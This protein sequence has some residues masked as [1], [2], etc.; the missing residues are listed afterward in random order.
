MGHNMIIS[1]VG[2]ADDNVLGAN[3]ITKLSNILY[4]A[5]KYCEKYNVTL[6]A[7]KTKLLMFGTPQQQ[8]LSVYN[9]IEIDAQKI[10]LSSSADHVGILRSIDGNLP[11]IVARISSYGRVIGANLSSGLARSHRAN[12]AASLKIESMYAT[13]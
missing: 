3:S 9:P 11:H 5:L 13:Q 6:C 8:L 10:E 7:D 1:S 2:L 4:L 12:P